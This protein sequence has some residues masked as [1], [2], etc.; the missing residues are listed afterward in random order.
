MIQR[1]DIVVVG[2]GPCG[3]FSAMAAARQGIDVT[4][5]EEHREIGTP[6]HCAG[7]ISIHGLKTLDIE[8]PSNIIENRVSK[9]RFYAPSGKQLCID[10]K[11]PV[12]QVID[13]VLFDRYL[14]ELSSQRGVSYLHGVDARSFWI[15]SNRVKGVCVGGEEPSKVEAKVVID[16]EGASADLLRKASLPSSSRTTFVTGVQGYSAKVS[17]VDLDSVEIYLGNDFAPG[18]FAWI[19]PRRD[20]SAKVGLATNRGNPRTLIERF[21]RKHPTASKKI[22]QP[23][24]SISFHPIPLGGPPS[25]TYGNGFIVVGDAA[26]QVKPTTGGGMVFGLTCSRIA[27]DTAAEAVLADDYSSEFLS[28]YQTLWRKQL[29]KEFKMGTATRKILSGLSDRAIDRIFSIGEAFHVGDSL[30]DTNEIDSQERILRGALIKPNIALAFLCSLLSS[31][32]P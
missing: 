24:S 13:R 32:L 4:V 1:S 18:F 19:I 22:M 16:A 30:G 14:S 7:H 31:F 27:G 6:V 21:S 15:D 12:T 25:R 17:D 29:G 5:I 9:A 2:G 23:L 8:I 28:R 20:G 26:S 10:C 11:R 3:S